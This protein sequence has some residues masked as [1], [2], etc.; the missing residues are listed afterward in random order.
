MQRTNVMAD[1]RNSTIDFEA[2]R[3][4]LAAAE[5]GKFSRAAKALGIEIASLS[6][7]IS[8]VEDELGL[9]LFERGHD[10]VRLTRGGQA[11]LVHARRALSDLNAMYCVGE[12]NA[13]GEEGRINLGVR[14]PVGA[15]LQSM[16]VSWRQ[17][18]PRVGIT[19]H[20]LAEND[21]VTAIERR[22][23]DLAI[24][25][26][27]LVWPRAFAIPIYRHHLVAALPRAHDL[28][29]RKSLDWD[30][31]RGETILAQG[32]EE[33]QGT[34]EFFASLLG[35]DV[36]IETHSASN[37]TILGLVAAGYGV[38]LVTQAQAQTKS[39]G[40]VFRRILEEDAILEVYLAWAPENE[41]AVVGRFVAFMRE[42]SA[43]RRLL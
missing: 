5:S 41:E 17:T 6:R 8:R 23:I 13:K 10:G 9:T 15:P 18:Y 27:H 32:W 25:A 43:S 20:E 16:L 38:T 40:V 7:R 28:A 34:R 39:P 22:R 11:V 26:K 12:R 42:L 3:Y 37:Q 1:H 24:L 19:V 4:L 36:K 30:A 14:L 21:I 35:N 2:L 31:F 29:R 33:S